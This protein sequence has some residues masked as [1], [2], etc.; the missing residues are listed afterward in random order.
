MKKIIVA[1]LAMLILATS[2]NVSS[3]AAVEGRGGI[4]GFLI[5]CCYGLRVGTE[6]NEGKDPHWRE[7]LR[8]VPIVNV[9]IAIWDGIECSQ[10]MTSHEFAAK[11]GTNWY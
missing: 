11:Y 4:G 10:G 2:V 8:I 7:W 9:V 6:W 5:G 1:A 3:A